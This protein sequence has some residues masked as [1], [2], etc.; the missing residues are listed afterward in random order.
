MYAFLDATLFNFLLVIIPAAGFAD[1]G[2]WY[3]YRVLILCSFSR[4]RR[5]NVI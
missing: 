4:R 3:E 1:L 5:T 2:M